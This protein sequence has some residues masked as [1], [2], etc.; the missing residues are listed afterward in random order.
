M[1]R[2]IASIITK[3]VLEGA[4]GARNAKKVSAFRA[5]KRDL[6]E[7]FCNYSGPTVNIDVLLTWAT[8]KFASVRVRHDARK[9]GES[10]YTV[11][12]LIS[13]ALNMMTG[14]STRPL[15]YASLMGFCFALFGMLILIYVI[16]KWILGANSVPGFAFL[17]SIITIF[18]GAQLIALGV[19]GEYVARMHTRTMD[20]PSYVIR[21]ET[22]QKKTQKQ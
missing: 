3:M 17:A 10:G 15:Q 16:T 18:A 19:I 7:A 13:H 9:F 21:E 5:F 4:M 14:F 1:L 11:S 12:K 22:R 8:T 6:R 2:D 20:Q